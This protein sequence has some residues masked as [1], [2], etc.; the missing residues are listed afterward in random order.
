MG[1]TASAAGSNGTDD[2]I[3][4]EIKGLKRLV[5]SDMRADLRR[6]NKSAISAS[7]YLKQAFV[8]FDALHTGFVEM[9][10]FKRVLSDVCNIHISEE[11]EVKQLVLARLTKQSAAGDEPKAQ[12]VQYGP[13]IDF[14]FPPFSRRHVRQKR[15]QCILQQKKV[16]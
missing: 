1:I 14:L 5:L 12:C 8:A 4:D 3:S 16:K 13:V 7:R 10:Q 6:N 15:Q 2:E 11:E 9:D